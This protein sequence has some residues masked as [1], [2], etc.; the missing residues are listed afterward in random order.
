MLKLMKYE[1]RRQRLSNGLLVGIFLILL[2]AFYGF[3]RT[4]N[5]T[6]LGI[7]LILMAAVSVSVLLFAPMEHWILFHIDTNSSQGKMLFLLPKKASSILGAKVLVALL[8]TV[9][10]YGLFFTAVPYCE[11]L[12]VEN[13]GFATG[14]VGKV[15]DTIIEMMHAAN[16]NITP[17]I[18]VWLSLI[19]SVMLFS[20][21]GLFVMAVPLPLEKLRSLTR[22]AG[23]IVAFALIVFVEMKIKDLLLFITS[24]PTVG[25]VFEIVYLTGVNLALFFGTAKLLDKKVSI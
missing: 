18:G 9:I 22:F 1:A 24:S 4:G 11:R 19:V 10:L 8:R 7:I 6:G 15:L 13:Y 23:Y 2:A 16:A 17:V 12:A 25:D 14:Y 5:V 3:Y 20:N 21:L